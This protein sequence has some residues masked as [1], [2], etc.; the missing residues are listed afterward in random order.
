MRVNVTEPRQTP[1]PSNVELEAK[2]V[3]VVVARGGEA[4]RQN[5]RLGGRKVG[6]HFLGVVQKNENEEE[7]LRSQKR[8][9]SGSS[10]SEAPTEMKAAAIETIERTVEDLHRARKTGQNWAWI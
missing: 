6:Q 3:V 4:R 9:A 7:M 2:P 5:P 10:K 8:E 1:I